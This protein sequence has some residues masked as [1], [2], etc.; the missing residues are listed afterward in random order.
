M[1][2]HTFMYSVSDILKDT[3]VEVGAQSVYF[4]QKGAFTGGLG[5]EGACSECSAG[6]GWG[7]K[8]V[9][10]GSG[11]WVSGATRYIATVARR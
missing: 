8:G 11:A 2:P 6:V 7:I 5:A 4:E 9:V 3:K 10:R 1:V